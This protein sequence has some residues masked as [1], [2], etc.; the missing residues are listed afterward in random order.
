MLAICLIVAIAATLVCHM[1]TM[2]AHVLVAM[3]LVAVVVNSDQCTIEQII[4]GH[5][6]HVRATGSVLCVFNGED[7]LAVVVA[8][9][10]IMA[11]SSPLPQLSSAGF[12]VVDR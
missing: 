5:A 7:L 8:F 2:G 4:I 6:V 12:L 3:R 11:A 10:F 1:Q 9:D